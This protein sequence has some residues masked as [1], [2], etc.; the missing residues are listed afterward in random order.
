VLKQFP[1]AEIVDVRVP[2]DAIDSAQEGDDRVSLAVLRD[3]AWAEARR[4]RAVQEGL[5]EQGDRK[6]EDA[7]QLAKAKR[8]EAMGNVL[9]CCSFDTTINE[10][11]RFLMARRR[12]PQPKSL[13]GR[14]S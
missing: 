10:R 3:V 7:G 12:P 8:F 11:V 5:V 14:D 13:T 1:G 9:D 4:I 2:D 6:S